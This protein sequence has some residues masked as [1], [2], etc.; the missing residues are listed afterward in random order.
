MAERKAQGLLECGAEVTIISPTATP[1]IRAKAAEGTL[2][3]QQ[4]EYQP[5]DLEGAFLAIAATDQQTV[6][7]GIAEEARSRNVVLNVVDNTPLCTFIAPSIV[8]RGDVTVALSTGG[9]SPALARKLRES[10][11][12]SKLLEYADLSKVLSAARTELKTR[13]VE[14]HPDHWQRCITDDLVVMVHDGKEQQAID[15]LL[16]KL[17]QGSIATSKSR[18]PT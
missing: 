16:E 4:R 5:G 1:D 7:E 15:Q 9:S 11:E 8:R 14:V 3:W 17:S 6:N 12:G 18:S 10:L 2:A 13:G